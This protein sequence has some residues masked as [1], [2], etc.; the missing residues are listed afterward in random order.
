MGFV[1]Q[2]SGFGT[3]ECLLCGI[4]EAVE[5]EGNVA[6]LFRGCNV[7]T[8]RQARHAIPADCCANS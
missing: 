2:G 6:C 8:C 4:L 5:V 7:P 3:W 1:P